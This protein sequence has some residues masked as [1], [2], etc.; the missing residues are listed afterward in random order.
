M[1]PSPRGVVSGPPAVPDAPGDTGPTDTVFPC[2]SSQPPQGCGQLCPRE[3]GAAD[4]G[5]GDEGAAVLTA[6]CAN[7]QV[8]VP[9]LD[10]ADA[11][12]PSLFCSFLCEDGPGGN[13]VGDY[14]RR[15]YGLFLKT[16]NSF[17]KPAV[18]HSSAMARPGSVPGAEP[19]ALR[20]LLWAGPGQACS[21]ALC[22]F[23]GGS[24]GQ[25]TAAAWSS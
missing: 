9:D 13:E 23:P 17:P 14:S 19:A 15:R 5:I 8:A 12:F 4:G 20:L 3:P 25:D 2:A 7:G 18:R 21:S 22:P 6:C 11:S 10:A 1:P 16:F 24:D